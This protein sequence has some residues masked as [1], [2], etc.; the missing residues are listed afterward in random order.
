MFQFE[1]IMVEYLNNKKINSGKHICINDC[2]GEKTNE[3]NMTTLFKQKVFQINT[4]GPFSGILC[5]HAELYFN[6]VKNG[7][8]CIVEN[9]SLVF[10]NS[11]LIK[12]VIIRLK[13]KRI[14]QFEPPG[15]T[16]N[17]LIGL[18][19]TCIT[20]ALNRTNS[21]L[22]YSVTQLVLKS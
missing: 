8:Y 10:I 6:P 1:Y 2:T 21:R 15:V 14:R 18:T 7:S 12:T 9:I 22:I 19:I 16:Y 4:L 5:M 3:S 20:T 17:Y 13:M 11:N